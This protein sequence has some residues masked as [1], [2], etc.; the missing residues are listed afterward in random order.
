MRFSWRLGLA[1]LL[2]IGSCPLVPAAEPADSPQPVPAARPPFD[3][4]RLEQP[5]PKAKVRE[6]EVG[7]HP[8]RWRHQLDK[9]AG[10][11]YAGVGF[12]VPLPREEAWRRSNAYQD[13]GKTMPGVKAV[14]YVERSDTRELIQIDVKVLWKELTLNFE[15]EKHPPSLLRF[16]LLN[17]SI[18]EYQGIC[19]YEERIDPATGAAATSVD[20][21]TWVDPAA[22]MPL[23]L[24]LAVERM[25][26]L[27]GA[28]EFLEAAGRPAP[29]ALPR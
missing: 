20:L 1:A 12:D 24:L 5:W 29:E 22:P 6:L 7:R 3:T 23:R 15:M 13:I 4:S 17:P 28:R 25:A 10:G 27:Q 9:A 2:L 11:I 16:R 8:V 18:G 26:L 21:A 14:R 19:R